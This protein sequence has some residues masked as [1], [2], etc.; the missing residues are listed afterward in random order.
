[1][2]K[3]SRRFKSEVV[4]VLSGLDRIRFRGTKRFVSTVRGM[5]EYLWKRRIL[6]KDFSNFAQAT[7]ATHR[8]AVRE[9]AGLWGYPNAYLNSSSLSKEDFA[10]SLACQMDSAGIRY[11][12]R[13]N[14]FIDI[15]DLSAA[16]QLAIAQLETNWPVVLVNLIRMTNPAHDSV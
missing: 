13:D 5:M 9:Q 2:L 7:T 4:G 8:C 1:M 12:K 10:L 14:H 11:V 16:S 6:L 15:A 3:F